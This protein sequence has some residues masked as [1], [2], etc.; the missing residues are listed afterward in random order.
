MK[1]GYRRY[2]LLMCTKTHYTI[3]CTV[4]MVPAVPLL[5]LVFLRTETLCAALYA[6]HTAAAPP[7][8][9]STPSVAIGVTENCSEL[10]SPFC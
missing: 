9:K 2:G 6:R 3:Q 8:H 1:K 10:Q 4:I 5:M 7:S